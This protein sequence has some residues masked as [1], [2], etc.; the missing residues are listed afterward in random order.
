MPKVEMTLKLLSVGDCS[1]MYC[2]IHNQDFF[3]PSRVNQ[4]SSVLSCLSTYRYRKQHSPCPDSWGGLYIAA[5][6]GR[7]ELGPQRGSYRVPDRHRQVD[8][9]NLL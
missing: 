2:T 1:C 3:P 8:T 4:K 5:D 9:A 6:G 7:R